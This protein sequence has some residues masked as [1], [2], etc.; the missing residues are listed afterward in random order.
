MPLRKRV[1]NSP[2]VWMPAGQNN[3]NTRSTAYLRLLVNHSNL[4]WVSVFPLTD[5]LTYVALLFCA[6]FSVLPLQLD[7]GCIVALVL[8]VWFCI[9]LWLL[10]TCHIWPCLKHKLLELSVCWA[11]LNLLFPWLAS[12]LATCWMLSMCAFVGVGICSDVW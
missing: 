2:S 11:L 4:S 12:D 9:L 1:W 3:L 10:F 7:L 5:I 8:R 6:I